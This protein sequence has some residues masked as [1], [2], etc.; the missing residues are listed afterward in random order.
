MSK[1]DTSLILGAAGQIGTDLVSTLRDLNGVSKVIAEDVKEQSGFLSAS[2]P[3]VNVDV[4]D[5]L[6]A[7][8]AH[9][10]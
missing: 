4:L 10:K 9:K 2:G 3:L 1:G 5:T 7:D 8:D 6:A